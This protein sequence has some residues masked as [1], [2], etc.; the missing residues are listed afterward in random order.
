LLFNF[1]L[2]YAIRKVQVNQD[3]LKLNGKR[4]LQVYADDVR[5]LGGSLHTIKTN[6]EALVVAKK[7]GGLEVNA[8]KTKYVVMSQHQN[9]GRSPSIQTDNSA[10]E[11]VEQFKYLGK[12]P[13]NQNSL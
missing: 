13:R 2:E 11:S 8:D 1:V 10:F 9:A 5:I 12:P 4:Q 3:D 7:E 6:T